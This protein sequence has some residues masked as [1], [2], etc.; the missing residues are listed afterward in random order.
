MSDTRP[1]NRPEPRVV[2]FVEEGP[3]QT[4]GAPVNRAPAAKPE[5]SPPRDQVRT[6][7]PVNQAPLPPPKTSEHS[8]SNG[9]SGSSSK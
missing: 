9:S 2:R 3:K 8:D 6:G 1:P 5:A 4:Y 7:A